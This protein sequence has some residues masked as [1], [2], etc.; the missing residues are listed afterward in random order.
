MKRIIQVLLLVLCS[1]FATQASSRT[2]ETHFALS[3]DARS[4]FSSRFPILSEG[5]VVI[6]ADWKTA[7]PH[8][9]N[10][11]LTMSLIE[12]DG[13]IVTSVIG[14]S[15]LRLAHN[16]NSLEV[17]KYT[18]P[19]AAQW[20][21]KIVNDV[22]ADRSEVSG[23]LRITIPD[24]ARTIEDSQFTLPGPGN[25]Q[26]IPFEVPS[27]GKID[28][29]VS[30]DL[31]APSEDSGHALVVSLIHPGESRT[32]ARR[33][34]P[35]PIRVEHQVTED[36]LDRGGRWIVKVQNDA[37]FRVSGRLRIIYTPQL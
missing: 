3:E 27:P 35:S 33:Q 32:L 30:W 14:S 20:I 18:R 9:G 34:G 36:A 5:R 22:D 26:E 15:G 21:V 12:P 19:R 8:H 1:C 17:D 31:N 28:I 29:E 24:T 23:I 4:E 13:T 37:Q 10:V 11:S 6:E 16:A 25:A 2:L 7:N